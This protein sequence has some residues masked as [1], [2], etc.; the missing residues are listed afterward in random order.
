MTIAQVNALPRAEFVEELGWIFEH[1]P[2]VAERAWDRRPFASLAELHLAMR[3]VVERATRDEQ[4]ALLCAHPD[5]GSR[6]SMSRASKDEQAGAFASGGP[7][8]PEEL[9]RYRRKFGS[10]FIYAV[11]GGSAPSDIAFALWVRIEETAEEEF[12][13]A[14]SEVSSIAWFR[15]QDK[16][17][18]S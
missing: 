9:Q 17:K 10:P 4:L 7:L 1:S 2:W 5:L 12:Q 15:L 6:A 14:L 11:K 8:L 13:Q 16:V 3:A 18:E